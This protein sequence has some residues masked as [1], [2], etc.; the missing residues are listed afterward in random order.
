MYDW[1]KITYV[2]AIL[3]ENGGQRIVGIKDFKID[4]QSM[5]IGSGIYLI[6]AEQGS[7]I[8]YRDLN[9][10]EPRYFKVITKDHDYQ[11]Q[12][13]R[14]GPEEK[15]QVI[16]GTRQGNTYDGTFTVMGFEV[17]TSEI[18]GD[19]LLHDSRTQDDN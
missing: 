18:E 4:E 16:E 11:H 17:P 9:T 13:I 14:V 19:L 5:V 6:V 8:R 3:E 12:V 10:M 15:W 2:V 1:H 7:I